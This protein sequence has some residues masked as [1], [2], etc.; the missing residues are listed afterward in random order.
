MTRT[1]AAKAA[2]Q[3]QNW[4]KCARRPSAVVCAEDVLAELADEVAT[5]AQAQAVGEED[6]ESLGLAADLPWGG[7]CRCR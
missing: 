6:E 7:V 3:I 1:T 5:D 2:G 4:R